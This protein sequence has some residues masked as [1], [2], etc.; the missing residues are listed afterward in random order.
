MSKSGNSEHLLFLTGHLAAPGLRRVLEALPAVDFSWEVRDLGISVAALMTAAMIARRLH[1]VDGVSRVIVPGLCAGDMEALSQRLGVPVQR[2]PEDFRDLPELFGQQRQVPA[3]DRYRVQIFA[4]IVEAPK[5]SVEAILARAE[6]YRQDGADV[7]DLGGLPGQPFPH[8]QDSVQALCEQGFRV[9]MDS[10]DTSELLQGAEAGAAYLLSLHEGNLWVAEEVEAV[11]VLIPQTAGDLPSL[12]RAM[13]RL[14]ALGRTFLADS[15][16]DPI[17]FGF[18]DSV[19]R[20][21]ELR[22]RFPEVDIMM[23]VG[24]LTELTEAD[25]CGINMLLAGMASE[26]DAAAVLTTEV[27]R[28]ACS[29]VYEFDRARRICYAAHTNGALPKG[30][31]SSLTPLHARNPYPDTEEDIIAL[32]AQIRDPS[33]RIR[34]LEQGLAIFNREG[35]HFGQDPF[36]LFPALTPLH[37]DAPHA[38][39]AGVELARAEIAWRLGKRYQQDRGLDWGAAIPP[40]SPRQQPSETAVRE[41]ALLAASRS[42]RKS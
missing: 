19:V 30:L 42:L 6:R 12:Y 16:L 25:T 13:E 26:L 18:T 38:F 29:A 27:S 23:G 33:Y 10:M 3:L 28:H 7:I 32:A 17:H 20:Y 39:Y 4:E 14:S 35:L 9:S 40:S 2:G 5:L 22:Q 1:D 34:V 15:I 36:A 31:D 41:D 24:N 8:L 11:P 37:K 21:K